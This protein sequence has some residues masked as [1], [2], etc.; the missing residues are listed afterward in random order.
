MWGRMVRMLGANRRKTTAV[1]IMTILISWAMVAQRSEVYDVEYS[2]QPLLEGFTQIVN[3]EAVALESV[4]DAQLELAGEPLVLE[5]VL[6]QDMEQ[7]LLMFYT[8]DVESQVLMDGQLVYS[9]Q[10]EEGFEF[11]ETPGNQWN[12]V[13]LSQGDGEKTVR[14]VLESSFDNRFES[15]ISQIFLV[16]RYEGNLVVMKSDIFRIVMAFLLA[17]MG[18][19]AYVNGLIWKRPYTHTYFMRLGGVYFCTALWLSAMCGVFYYYTGSAVAAYLI[20]MIMANYLPVV[21]HEFFQA[22]YQRKNRVID[23][24]EWLV[25]G[26]FVGQM[27]LQFV[28]HV[29]M[30]HLLPVT[31]AVYGAGALTAVGVVIY[32]I[33]T[34]PRGEINVPLVSLA[35]ILLGAVVE[36]V[37]LIRYPERTDWIG[38]GSTMGMLVY[39]VI[40]HIYLLIRE[41]SLDTEKLELEQNYHKLQNTTLMQQIKAHFFFNTLNT[42]SALCKYDAM[43]AD[44]AINIFAKYMRSY[45]R[46]INEQE[47]IPFEKELEIVEGTLQIEKLRFPDCFAYEIDLDCRDFYVPPLSIQPIVENSMIH[48]LRRRRKD[49]K[50]TI[51]TREYDRYVQITVADNGVG[52]DIA[53]LEERESIGLKNMKKRV[54]LMAK[55]TVTIK[56]QPQKGTETTITIPKSQVPAAS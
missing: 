12:Y 22:V 30:L 17:F 11:L 6:P 23:W 46:L 34:T 55:G 9:G 49:G 20:S 33:F 53:L 10:M 2:S 48:G 5:L 47:N 28:F 1:L 36:V 29:S 35:V 24:L 42:I 7:K 8:K 19:W 14:L 3:G 52:F 44:N 4:M 38:M 41:S 54:E 31:I 25:W 37:L 15:T 50:I 21:V 43:E 26:N 16:D 18:F 13:A 27:V 40:N 39:M 45:M 32:H 51:R 56:S